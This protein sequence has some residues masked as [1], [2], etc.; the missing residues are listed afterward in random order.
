MSWRHVGASPEHLLPQCGGVAVQDELV[1]CVLCVVQQLQV[2]PHE[3]VQVLR[4]G[5]NARTK[6]V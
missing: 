3:L 1:A 4:G 2:V 6:T 5:S